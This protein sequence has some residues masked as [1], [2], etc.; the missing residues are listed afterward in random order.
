MSKQ[1]GVPI[2]PPQ[3]TRLLDMCSEVRGV[4]GGVVPGA[5][6]HD[7]IALIIENDE[8]VVARLEHVLSGWRVEYAEGQKAGTGKVSTLRVRE[9]MEGVRKESPNSYKRWVE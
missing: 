4:I 5:G 7:A 2:E 1:S 3:Q 9:E 8:E 6:G